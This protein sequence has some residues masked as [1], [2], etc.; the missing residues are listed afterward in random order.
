MRNATLFATAA[1]LA[2][3]AADTSHAE[4]A[5][6]AT[7]T[8]GGA[9][10]DRAPPVCS[11]LPVLYDQDNG[12]T[13]SGSAIVSQRFGPGFHM[14]DSQAADDFVVP[15]GGWTIHEVDV[16]GQYF[17]GPGPAVSELVKIYHNNAG[18]PGALVA[19]VNVMGA[20][21]AGSFC[22][23]I[24]PGITL[25]PGRYWLSVIVKMPF[26]PNGE[27]GWENLVPPPIMKPAAWRNVHGGFGT[28]TVWA[29]QNSCVVSGQGDNIFIL[30]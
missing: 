13:D 15:S 3:A 29:P 5:R 26:N 25:A 7:R 21:N 28:C 14:Y 23:P 6:P 4:G 8:A 2:L 24:N 22:L 19:S 17:N 10:A 12:F 18:L 9:H 20:D 16:V 1:L 27:W 11:A 30:R